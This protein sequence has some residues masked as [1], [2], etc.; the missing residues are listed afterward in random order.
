M[1][2]R[3]ISAAL[4]LVPALLSTSDAA[5]KKAE[6][7]GPVAEIKEAIKAVL[8]AIRA[9]FDEGLKEN[10]ELEGRLTV[11]FKGGKDGAPEGVR[12]LKDELGAAAVAACIM[13]KIKDVRLPPSATGKTVAYPFVFSPTRTLAVLPFDNMTGDKSLDWLKS[14][15]AESLVTKLGQVPSLVLVDRM[16]LDAVL[17]E[18]ALGQSGAMDEKTAI[19]A[20]RMTG[21]RRVIVGAFQRAGK[22]TRLTARV[23]EV[24]TGKVRETAM[25]DGKLDDLFALQDQLAAKVAE[26]LNLVAT[27]ERDAALALRINAS[28]PILE[29]LGKANNALTGAGEPKDLKKA[30]ALFQQVI[31]ADPRIP[32]A[33]FG[34]ARALWFDKSDRRIEEALRKAIE[35]RPNYHEALTMLGFNLW[36][37]LRADEA[38]EL[39]KKAV[40]LKPDYAMGHY[41]LC[42][43]LATKG[44][45]DDALPLCRHAIDL[46]PADPEFVSQYGQLVS[47]FK[48]DH[49]EA[50]R[51]TA[52]GI[53]LKGRGEWNFL[54]HAVVQL[55][56]GDAAGCLSSLD[57]GAKLRAKGAEG[58]RFA[59]QSDFV[60]AGCLAK[61]GKLS[62]A[63]A[64][65]DK[66]P[67]EG[68]KK[69]IVKK[70]PWPAEM[71][72]F[73]RLLW[74]SVLQEIRPALPADL[75]A[76]P[77][78]AAK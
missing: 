19:A 57:E 56:A 30:E 71:P 44:K 65:W 55:A 46:D 15:A 20:G 63:R 31:N 70:I 22:K 42:I 14:G 48:L 62:E 27:P 9:C 73:A 17:S 60:R 38:F 5:E 16:K 61:Q 49:A 54:T 21:A 8:P 3:I 26:V 59:G 64:A 32:E 47:L 23:I 78:P 2:I 28:R 12:I 43:G 74:E 7:G 52:K 53:A 18:Q 39:Q 6:T 41:G 69:L 37:N 72:V 77:A 35:L 67:E 58:A 66:V 68:P 34:L 76:S 25:A 33:R 29:L 50:A 10:R 40:A 13:A 4:A 75:Q 11:E 1:R 45:V 24:E 36:L 51:W